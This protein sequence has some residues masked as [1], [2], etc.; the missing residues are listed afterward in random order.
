MKIIHETGYSQEECEQYRP[1]VYSNTIQSLMAI[2]RA[3]GQLRID[4]AD[5]SKT[6]I[7][8]QFFTYASA[9]EEGELTPELVSLMKKLWTDPG[10]QQCFARSREYQLNDS[11]AYYLNSLDR[12]SQPAYIPTQQD[13]LRTRVKTTGIVETHFSFKSIHF[14][15]FDVGGQRS[16]RKKWIHC[17]EGVTAIIFCVALSGYDLVLAEDE[18][19]NRMIESMKLFD[20]ICNSKWFV[21]TS[22]I[23]FLNKKDLFE[24]K[25]VRSPLTICFPEY[26]GSNTYEEASSYIRM[27]FENLNRRK[28]Q[29]EI[30]THLT[31]ATDTSNIQ[32]VFDAVSDV[33]I[34]NNLK[35]CGLF[36]LQSKIE[37]VY[38]LDTMIRDRSFVHNTVCAFFMASLWWYCRVLVACCWLAVVTVHGS[39]LLTSFEVQHGYIYPSS[40]TVA[41]G[42]VLQLRLLVPMQ[43]GDRCLYREPGSPTDV[44]VHGVESEAEQL[45]NRTNGMLRFGDTECSI[46]VNPVHQRDGGFWRLTLV[47]GTER[48][49]GVTMVDV[50]GRPAVPEIGVGS[51]TISSL[52]E[53]SPERTE[54]CFVQR[55]SVQDGSN[56]GVVPMYER[57]H[58]PLSETDP[59]GAGVWSVIAG[60]QGQMREM[61]YG[62]HIENKEEQ[63]VSVVHKEL[64]YHVLSCTLLYTK[65]M[66]KFCRF[67]RLADGLGLN[68]I[69]GVGT[70]RYGYIGAGFERNVCGLEILG[71]EG[72]DKGAWK[73]LLG[74]GDETITKVSGAIVDNSDT[75][76]PL[77]I[78]GRDETVIAQ[79]GTTTSLHCNANKPID[80][81]WFRGPHGQFYSLSESLTPDR[82][83]ASHHYYWYS[84]IA[85]SMGECGITFANL[86]EGEHTGQWH[87]Y[88][89]NGHVSALEVSATFQV[90]ISPSQIISPAGDRVEAQLDFPALL[91]CDSI[92]RGTPLQYC[93]F[94]TPA[95][96]AFSLNEN[97]TTERP[98]LERFYSNP[99]HNLAKGSC[100][101]V[102]ASVRLE[103]FGEW[104]CAGKIEGHPVEHI[105]GIVVHNRDEDKQPEG[106]ADPTG[107]TLSAASISGMVIGAV[108]VV[109]GAV[110]LGYWQFRKRLHRQ[111]VAA[112]EEIQMRTLE[113]RARTGQRIS[114]ISE[115]SSSNSQTAL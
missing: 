25:I 42:E 24:E 36:M 48:I 95:G 73:C 6:D 31:C 85:L 92:P 50:I 104:I 4:F 88:V 16:E 97:V 27:K 40:V 2:I 49:R 57:C 103:D 43:N 17:F 58:L 3:M 83:D 23:L 94:V 72:L 30:Y 9:T 78:I 15:M 69:P 80:Y 98:V 96:E 13:V 93:R 66:L 29:K 64:D 89:G 20:S 47:R 44:D 37:F 79:N 7:A 75:T 65:L 102:I 8:R 41:E 18:E 59:T 71:P 32:F 81:C 62:I 100:S 115:S 82:Q 54:Y 22:I 91:G 114:V 84:G 21:E 61:S 33:I 87:C 90:R 113:E 12:I 26:T 68:V 105:Y 74:Y 99:N 111:T 51:A 106:N 67:V 109:G 70:S 5:P 46:R 52:D 108:A 107:E 38:H 77:A 76:P 19:M 34:K 35:D 53:I 86:M 112:N 55:Q 11:A 56:G 39:N 101:L 14:K 60:V 63:I 45:A 1:V 110:G 10:V 28:D